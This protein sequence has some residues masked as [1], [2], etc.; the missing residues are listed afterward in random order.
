MESAPPAIAGDLHPQ[1]NYSNLPAYSENKNCIFGPFPE[2]I[3]NRVYSER[4][5]DWHIAYQKHS[6]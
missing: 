4:A 3:T 5:Y 2:R 6:E 1:D